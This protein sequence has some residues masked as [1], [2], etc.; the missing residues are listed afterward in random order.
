[1]STIASVETFKSKAQPAPSV[2]SE[3]SDATAL[4]PR[5][6]IAP[7]P[8][9]SDPSLVSASRSRASMKKKLA[10]HADLIS[11]LSMPASRSKSIVSAR[12]IRTHRSRLET[13][14]LED[15]MKELASDESK[16][17]R[18][19]RTLADGVIPILLKCVLSKSDAAV[20]AGL[21][22]RAP[23]SEKEAIAE[24]SKA[25]HDM[26]VAIQRLKGVHTSI[27]KEDHFKFLIWAQRALSIYEG[28]VKTWRLG[29]QDVVVSLA[30]EGEESTVSSPKTAES[31]WDQGLPRNED[32][33]IVDGDGERV[34]VAFLLKRPLVRLKFLSKTLKVSQFFG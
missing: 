12:S 3:L 9:L 2:Y 25:I 5:D 11:V 29:F 17:M 23:G 22:K 32:G 20:A 4:P 16:Y 31:G 24:A 1:L 34:D 8:D 30:V 21:F 14:T 27:P 13:A 33:Y 26:S 15:L 28:Y 19:L 6:A 7:L 18:E 10:S